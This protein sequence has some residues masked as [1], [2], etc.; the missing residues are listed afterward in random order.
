MLTSP[1]ADAFAKLFHNAWI[2]DSGTLVSRLKLIVSTK[3][4]RT[5]WISPAET[6][7]TSSGTRTNRSRSNPGRY[8]SL[9]PGLVSLTAKT[10]EIRTMFIGSL[11][12]RRV[13]TGAAPRCEDF[14][15][16]RHAKP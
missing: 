15:L 16:F 7:G 11:R 8:A 6:T 10:T 1:F 2:S 3:Y 13:S 5:K 14:A 12:D 4:W 9:L